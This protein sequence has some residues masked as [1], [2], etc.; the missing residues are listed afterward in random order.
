MSQQI[1][2]DESRQLTNLET[3]PKGMLILAIIRTLT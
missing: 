3:R 2:R 1:K